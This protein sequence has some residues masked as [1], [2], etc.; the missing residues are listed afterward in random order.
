MIKIGVLSIVFSI[1]AGNGGSGDAALVAQSKAPAGQAP[2]ISITLSLQ[3]QEFATGE[4]PLAVLTVKNISDRTV[5]S[6]RGDTSDFRVKV[7][8]EKGEAPKT[9]YHRRIR[10]E[11]Y[12]GELRPGET[13]LPLGSAVLIPIPPGGTEIKEVDL[14]A[15]YELTNPGEY[16]A[17]VEVW[18]RVSK[19][20]LR[21]N[22]VQFTMEAPAK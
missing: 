10:G 12:P 21:T 15:F 16:T 2:A 22:T 13:P 17:Y 20:R 1:L 9:S 3:K 5:S 7:E 11:R 6:L 4:R 19:T 14:A 8:W 18:D